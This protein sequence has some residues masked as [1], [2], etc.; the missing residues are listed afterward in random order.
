MSIDFGLEHTTPEN[1]RNAARTAAGSIRY[2][3]AATHVVDSGGLK[4]PSDADA[5]LAE[6]VT[7]LG[8]VPQLLDQLSRWLVAECKTGQVRVDIDGI[9]GI[10]GVHSPSVEAIAVA[11]ARRWIIEA[12][13]TLEGPRAALDAGRQITATLKGLSDDE[14][15]R[16]G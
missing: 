6:L 1:V 13:A 9:A 16:L 10:A 8:D 15:E 7:L 4:Y 3:T 5:V 11:V 2:L 14:K 12:G